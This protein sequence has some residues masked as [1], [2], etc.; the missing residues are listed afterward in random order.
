[1]L[2]KAPHFAPQR[3]IN[4]ESQYDA[5]CQATYKRLHEHYTSLN[6][7]KDRKKHPVGIRRTVADP[8]LY[9]LTRWVDQTP[10]GINNYPNFKRFRDQMAADTGVVR[11]VAMQGIPQ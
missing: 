6:E 1:M 2:T 7:R 11:A 10:L 5:L 4:D 8:Y 9:V 3:F